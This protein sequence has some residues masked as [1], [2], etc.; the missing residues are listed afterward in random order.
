[1]I[2]LIQN[3]IENL[4]SHKLRVGLTIFWIIVGITSVVVVGSIGNGV[5]KQMEKS[6]QNI[7]NLQNIVIDFNPIDESMRD[8]LDFMSPISQSDVENIKTMPGI[9]KITPSLTSSD[10]FIS[11][12]MLSSGELKYDKLTTYVDIYG[13]QEDGK[14]ENENKY[15]IIYG[16]KI[17]ESDRNKNVIV[18][19]ENSLMELDI[20]SQSLV[21]KGVDINGVIYEVIGIM[22]APELTDEFN[23][24]EWNPLSYFSLVPKTTME[25][26]TS[27]NQNPSI[28]Y[29]SLDIQVQK[30]YNVNDIESKVIR[31]LSDR[32][33]NIQGYYSKKA[34]EF[35]INE[36]LDM[37]ISAVN[38]FVLLVTGISMIVGGIGVMNIMY[39]S[40]IERKREI[41]IRRAI[42]AT[43]FK[44]ITQFLSEAVVITISGC[45]LGLIIGSVTVNFISGKM[46]F[47]A[48][49]SIS[50]YVQA[51][52]SS[53]LTGIVSGLIPAIKA[54][55][56]DPIEAIQG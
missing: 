40:V 11:G 54:S 41:G 44:I 2:T 49:P 22:S 20:D 35:D 46:P 8:F 43:P 29:S 16:R 5:K 39:V 56:V 47:E 24:Y 21:G 51:I 10:G 27:M 28:S 55:K 4:K 50:I 12:E 13:I 37:M 7:S 38:K 3:S 1:M 14:D 23:Q 48:I 17:K 30:G 34:N 6:T 31:L 33:P 52:I 42:G 25:T 36:D 18:L 19:N 45:I 9:K 15:N 32:H 53:I 26:L